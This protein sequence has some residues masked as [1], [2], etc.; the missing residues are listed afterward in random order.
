MRILH[1]CLA[2]SY[3]EGLSYQENLLAQFHKKMGYEVEV[4][5]GLK[6]FNKDGEYIYKDKA[7][8]YTNKYG[9]HVQQLPY[10]NPQKMGKF[11]RKYVGTYKAI[12]KAK[13]DVIFSHG[14]QFADVPILIQYMKKHTNVM[15]YMDNHGDF[16]NSATNWISKNAKHKILWKHYA[17]MI[18][19][20]VKRFYGVLPARVD[21]LIN[22]Y[23]LPKDKVELLVMGADDDAVEEASRP[24]VK[25][26]IREKYHISDDD[27]LIMNGG[28][29]DIAKKQTLLL[30]DAVNQMEN[31]KVK[32]IVFGS[33]IP[34][35]KADVEKRCSDKVQ[36]IGWVESDD[37]Y[38]YYAAA[39]LVCFPG[40]HSVFWEQVVGLGIPMVV[41]Y[42]DGTTHVDMD[43]N[44]KF[45][46]K[47][48]TQEIKECLESIT[49][50]PNV[51]QAMRECAN[52]EK[53][54]QFLYSGIAHKAI[55][56]AIDK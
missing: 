13:P 28:K 7:E 2:A 25:K 39:D 33:V 51:Y 18:N 47:D 29:I 1:L 26:S 48:S 27:F 21:F 31:P 5:S 16:S 35:M 42:W 46:H 6:S 52:S 37:S 3:V 11:L 23:G 43:G 32:L 10:K 12:E 38:K 50:N 4:I 45:L 24:A 30:M 8:E 41:K 14:V 20:Y 17:Q 22:L 44:V 56:D 53:R 55:R 49:D 40:R 36:Y 54:K 9:I 15:L 19:P 34:E